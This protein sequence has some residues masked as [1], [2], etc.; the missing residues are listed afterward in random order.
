M[1]FSQGSNADILGKFNAALQVMEQAGATLVDIDDFELEA[2]N[3]WGKSLLVLEYEFKA[4]LDE[5]LAD[6][7]PAVKTR[8]LKQVIAFNKAHENEEMALFDQDLLE[9]TLTK[10]SLNDAE[11]IKARDDVQSATRE[12]GIDHLLAKHK[13]DM[14][15]SPSGPISP[16]IDPI[17][18][19]VWP[20]W[21]GA[22][23]LAAIAGYPHITVPMGNV[24]GV[25]IGIS[26]MGAKNMDAKILAYGY[27]Y[28]QASHMR[29]DPQYH[30]DAEGR[31]EIGQAM[32]AYKP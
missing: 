24:H 17:N 28:E 10:D 27:A 13:V 19:D 20:A 25:P 26:I 6:T 32:Q 16:R 31:S 7:A 23:H 29:A 14:L 1:R 3:F 21:A 2:E 15:V 30:K 18:G 22:G 4:G 8:S 11:Y 5:Y 12:D 9:E